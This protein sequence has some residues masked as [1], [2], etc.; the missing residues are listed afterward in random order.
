MTI[1]EI[2]ERRNGARSRCCIANAE[3][4]WNLKRK[5]YKM[6]M[7]TSGP[8]DWWRSETDQRQER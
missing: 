2:G 4:L 5:A 1:R 7:E 3:Q 8:K 6:K